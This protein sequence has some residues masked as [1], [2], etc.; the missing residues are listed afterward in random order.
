[1]GEPRKQVGCW[2][3]PGL[4]GRQC[5]GKYAMRAPPQERCNPDQVTRAQKGRSRLTAILGKQIDAHESAADQVDDLG[6]RLS[7]DQKRPAGKSATG[8]ER[9]GRERRLHRAVAALGCGAMLIGRK[10]SSRTAP[11]AGA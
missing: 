10:V 4:H 9:G 2:K 3:L 8:G 6:A 1:M 7:L 5:L 11:A